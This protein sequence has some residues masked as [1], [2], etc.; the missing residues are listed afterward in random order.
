MSSDMLTPPEA[1]HTFCPATALS[2]VYAGP[3][4]ES[5]EKLWIQEVAW[6][7]ARANEAN[8]EGEIPVS[9]VDSIS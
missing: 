3:Y 2:R 7:E 5:N 4:G 1:F 6:H 9:A 8:S